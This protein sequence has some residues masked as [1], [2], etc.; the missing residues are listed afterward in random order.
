M[1]ASAVVSAVGVG[2]SIYEGNKSSANQQAAL[3]AQNTA[4][5]KAE[6]N[7][8]STSRKS[9]VAENEANQKTPDV[10][11]ILARAQQMGNKGQSSTMLTGPG[12]V[13]SGMSLGKS[14]L[15]GS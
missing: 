11:S 12:G 14:T 13:T 15:L 8:L 5:D 1:V 7:S 9:A 3:R 2:A 10:A 6:A 4:Q